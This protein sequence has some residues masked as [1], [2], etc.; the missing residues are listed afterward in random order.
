MLASLPFGNVRVYNGLHWV[1]DSYRCEKSMIAVCCFSIP[2]FCGKQTNPSAWAEVGQ[3]WSKGGKM[4]TK[5]Q[6]DRYAEVLLWGLKIARRG[7]F[8]RRDIISIRYDRDAVVLAER[9]QAKILD[10]GMNPVM[11]VGLTPTMERNLFEKADNQQLAFQAPGEKEL[12]ENVHGG[13]YLHAPE[14]LTHLSHIDPRKI[15]K[16]AVARKPLRDILDRRED[17]GLFGWTLCM[18]PTAELAKQAKLSVRQYTNQIIKACYLDRKDP[19]KAWKVVFKDAMRLKKWM[20]GMDVEYYR[21]Q[22]RHTDLKI[23]PGKDRRWIGISGHNIPSFE[24][25]LS[26]DWRGT[27]GVFFA[28]QPSFRSGN[29]VKGVRLTFKKGRV[30]KVAAEKGKDFVVKQLSLDKGASKV[31]EFSLTD[32]RFSKINKFM[33]N[34]LYDEN[35]GGR[36]GNCHVA[37]GASYSDTYDGKPENLTKARKR[38]L[39]FNDSALHWDLVNTEKKT[40]TAHLASGKEVVVYEDGRFSLD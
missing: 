20:N 22:S 33:A 32:R 40:V 19:V 10:M 34:T 24:I 11:R 21:V 26:P 3:P 37:L 36:F 12:C 39:G 14:S 15:G 30:V 27:E 1:D 18:L 5:T 2:V 28:D 17:R 9:L 4:L 16:V 29:Y 13:I 31:G 23:T 8:K 6:L 25:F 38:N 35:Y 7:S